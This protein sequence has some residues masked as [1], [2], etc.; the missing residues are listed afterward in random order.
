[1]VITDKSMGVSQLLGGAPG[2]PQS[3]RLCL[4]ATDNNKLVW[5][6]TP[7]WN[8]AYFKS[9]CYARH[10]NASDNQ[11]SRERRDF[12]RFRRRRSWTHRRGH[13]CVLGGG[14]MSS[15][16]CHGNRE[17]QRLSTQT[18]CGRLH[19]QRI[20]YRAPSSWRSA[21]IRRT[22][23][24]PSPIASATEWTMYC[25]SCGHP[26]LDIRLNIWVQSETTQ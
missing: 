2:L 22:D 25:M 16:I 9:R 7:N 18:S 19:V 10:A 17:W 4:W 12:P 14:V 3:L 21:D 24:L 26:S 15:S 11:Y 1:M 6:S 13:S 20:F 5:M 8:I 23:W